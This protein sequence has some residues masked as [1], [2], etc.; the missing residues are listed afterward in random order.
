MNPSN[1]VR[2]LSAIL[3]WNRITEGLP[4]NRVNNNGELE[5]SNRRYG[6]PVGADARP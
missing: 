1:Q 3:P 4:V 6:R 2:G 5:S